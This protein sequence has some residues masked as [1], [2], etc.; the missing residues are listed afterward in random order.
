MKDQ[1]Q[2]LGK[3]GEQSC[4]VAKMWSQQENAVNLEGVVGSLQEC[5]AA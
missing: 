4:V 5:E 1:D 3:L 2:R